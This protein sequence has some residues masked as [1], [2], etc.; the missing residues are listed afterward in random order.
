[1]SP[2]LVQFLVHSG[3]SSL[4]IL[5]GVTFDQ[6]KEISLRGYFWIKF[7]SNLLMSHDSSGVTS[8]YKLGQRNKKLLICIVIEP[9]QLESK[10][11]ALY[12]QKKTNWDH[13]IQYYK[14]YTNA[15]P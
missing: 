4:Q 8:I 13:L 10:A 2:Y 11:I 3:L 5:F 1:M 14:Y 12:G 15:S 9:A 6:L 7:C